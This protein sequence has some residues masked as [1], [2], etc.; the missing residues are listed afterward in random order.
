MSACPCLSCTC[1]CTSL[2]FPLSH[3]PHPHRHPT[4]TFVGRTEG[5]IVPAAFLPPGPGPVVPVFGWDPIFKPLEF[6]GTYAQ[7]P[8]DVRTVLFRSVTAAVFQM[9]WFEMLAALVNWIFLINP[10]TYVPPSSAML[11]FSL[12]RLSRRR[13]RSPIA[14]EHS[15][16]WLRTS[17]EKRCDGWLWLPSFITEQLKE[18]RITG[19][20]SEMWFVYTRGWAMWNECGRLLK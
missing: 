13:T 4:Q 5:H 17:E 19:N 2:I 9:L 12:S 6:E 10:S 20:S 7:M 15:L 11:Y 8:K 14:T 3:T 18:L 16:S 1:T